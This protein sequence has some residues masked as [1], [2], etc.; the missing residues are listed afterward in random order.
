[1]IDACFN[2]FRGEEFRFEDQTATVLYPDGTPNGKIVFRTEYLGAFPNFEQAM[3]RRGYYVINVTHPNYYAEYEHIHQMARFVREMAAKLGAS[4][5]CILSGVSAGGLQAFRFALLYPELVSVAY[6]DAPVLNLLSLAGF[7]D[8]ERDEALWRNL[9]RIYNFTESSILVY[10]DSPID[11]LDEFMKLDI[12]VVMVYG[13]S[14]TVVPYHENGK[15][16]EDYYKAHGGK[17]AVFGKKGCDHH[18]H[19]LEDP[20]P[21]IEFVEQFV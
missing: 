16:L 14:D 7:G 12:P 20:T 8:A 3:L 17:L 15:V 9:S 19:G 1:M 2:A 4:E 18:P 6:L 21:I 13:D 11:H 10:R 5:K